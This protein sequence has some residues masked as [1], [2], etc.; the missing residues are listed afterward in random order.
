MTVK[1]TQTL[2]EVTENF[3]T[4]RK[5]VKISDRI[6][7]QYPYYGASGVIDYVD[8]YTHDGEFLLIAEDGEN[9]RSR[10]T[11][12]AFIASGKFWA[13]N[14]AHVVRGNELC[15][16]RYLG[17]ALS[18]TDISGYL[19]GSTM[20]KLTRFAMDS[21]A[22]DL[23]SIVE[24][25]AIAEVLGAL[26]D[27]IAANAGLIARADELSSALFSGMLDR[28][29]L[30]PL[31]E[32]SRFVNGKA[33]TKNASGTGRVVIRI[34]ELNSGI[35]GSTVY[36]DIEVPD[37]YL[38]RPGDL[39]FAWSGSLTLHRW[40]RS[41][42]IINQHIFKV[43]PINGYPLWLDNQLLIRK[44]D[45]FK[46]IAADKATTMGHIQRRHL[47]PA[48]PVPPRSMIEKYDDAMTSL[49]NAA[50]N[51]E[52]ESL[53][54]AEIRDVLLPQLMSGKLRV[55]DAETQVEAVV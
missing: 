14:Q 22:L 49:W 25:K 9:L 52:Q 19:T 1:P 17:Y 43:I 46:A 10:S 48:V 30:I 16:T 26:D 8:G 35:G 11:P 23:P 27:K 51:S 47:E 3:D 39:L 44:L 38:A 53:R 54:L 32:V 4:L 55:K 34:A 21:I 29:D 37:D 28:A 31:T 50:L 12:V 36:N 33:F 40:F 6:R 42:G 15:V 20:P 41:E 24:Q 13:N 45:E 18:I 7:G 5:P 2:R